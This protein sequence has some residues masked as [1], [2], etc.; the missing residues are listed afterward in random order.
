M[1]RILTGL[2]FLQTPLIKQQT[3]AKGPIRTEGFTAGRCAN[4]S[5]RRKR[6]YSLQVLG[7]GR[8]IRHG[9]EEAVGEDGEHD[10]QAEQPG[11]L[12]K[13]TAPGTQVKAQVLYVPMQHID[14]GCFL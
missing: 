6:A 1:H 14:T 12:V 2:L 10:E 4:S 9:H 11:N 3:Q 7:P 13:E 5:I 8:R